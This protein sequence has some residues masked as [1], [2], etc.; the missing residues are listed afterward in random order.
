MNLRLN[1]QQ[2]P[3]THSTF[4]CFTYMVFCISLWTAGIILC[5]KIIEALYFH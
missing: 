4:A 2:Y 3:P 5:V 1:H